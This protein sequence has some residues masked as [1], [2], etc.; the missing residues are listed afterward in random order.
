MKNKYQ[1]LSKEERKECRT[2]Y[3]ST[4]K[5]K[6]MHLR[7]IRL[8][9]IGVIGILFGIYMIGNGIITNKVAWYDYA[10]AIPLLLASVTFLIGAFVIR[11]RVFNQF[12]LKIPRFKNK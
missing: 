8:I 1:R 6:E 12:A 7:L 2:M 9:I 5:G 3:Y 4:P 10:I 11:Q